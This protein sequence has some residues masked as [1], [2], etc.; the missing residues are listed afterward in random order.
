MLFNSLNK[1]LKKSYSVINPELGKMV[2][3]NGEAEY[4]YVGTILNNLFKNNNVFDLIKIYASVYT[5]YKSTL[6]NTYKTF[7]YAFP[8][9]SLICLLK[10]KFYID[11]LHYVGLHQK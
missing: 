4:I 11:K 7:I 3:P 8:H 10:G 1:K 5:Y 9:V 2:F 6:G